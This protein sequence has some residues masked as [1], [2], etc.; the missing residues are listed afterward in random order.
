GGGARSGRAR[1]RIA[2]SRRRRRAADVR[3]AAGVRAR[4]AGVGE[5]VD[6]TD[7][8]QFR[9]TVRG[10]R[11]RAVAARDLKQFFVREMT[12]GSLLDGLV[13]SSSVRRVRTP[14][15]CNGFATG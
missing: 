1:A 7:V 15:G 14:A 5:A 6:R 10:E 8:G 12:H 13:G 2:G 9:Q 3:A 11:P 4:R